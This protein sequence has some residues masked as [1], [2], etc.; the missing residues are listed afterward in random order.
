MRRNA[1]E[2]IPE[3]QDLRSNSGEAIR[4]RKLMTGKA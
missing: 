1:R 2:V 3:K 4:A